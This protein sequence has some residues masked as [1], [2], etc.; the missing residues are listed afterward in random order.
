V[1]PGKYTEVHNSFCCYK[2]TENNKVH[3]QPIAQRA[4]ARS[5]VQGYCMTASHADEPWQGETVKRGRI[6]NLMATFFYF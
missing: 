2:Q 6:T 3:C 4:R 5:S 1:A